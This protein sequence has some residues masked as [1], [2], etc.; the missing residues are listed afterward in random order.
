MR[1][2]I[3]IIFYIILY[4]IILF[5]QSYTNEESNDIFLID[6]KSTRNQKYNVFCYFI[7]C[8]MLEK[9]MQTRDVGIII[10]KNVSII[11]PEEKNNGSL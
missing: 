2:L 5:T 6:K 1:I 4:Y 10:I 8:S 11:E 7:G 3:Y 9:V